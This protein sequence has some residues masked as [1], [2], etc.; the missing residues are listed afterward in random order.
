MQQ[1]GDPGPDRVDAAL[2]TPGGQVGRVGLDVTPPRRGA[3]RPGDRER[4]VA[5]VVEVGRARVDQPVGGRDAH[6]RTLSAG[7]DT[8]PVVAGGGAG[9]N[10]GAVTSARRM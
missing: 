7:T 4:A 6:A 3:R 9:P 10:G 1:A 5:A 8:T 2:P